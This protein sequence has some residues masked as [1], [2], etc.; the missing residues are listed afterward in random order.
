MKQKEKSIFIFIVLILNYSFISFAQ[1]RIKTDYKVQKHFI[2]DQIL[3][4]IDQNEILSNVKIYLDSKKINDFFAQIAADP[5]IEKKLLKEN[6]DSIFVN[7]TLSFLHNQIFLLV[8]R[9]FN[10]KKE[11]T[12][13]SIF[14]FD[15]NNN[16]ISNTIWNIKRGVSFTYAIYWGKMVKYDVNYKRIEIEP[17][18]RQQII[19]ST[20]ASLDSLMHHFPEFKYSFD[21]K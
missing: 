9:T 3:T 7:T 14:Y 4:S 20:K 2:I 10:Q 6:S 15:N 12:Y 21:W 8:Y 1:Q 11:K 17:E 5:A 19:N 13:N 16:C 18:Q